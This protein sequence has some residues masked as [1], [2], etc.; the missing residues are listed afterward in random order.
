MQYNFGSDYW[1]ILEGVFSTPPYPNSTGPV[2]INKKSIT[3]YYW[4]LRVYK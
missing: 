4:E 1:S 2:T 3:E